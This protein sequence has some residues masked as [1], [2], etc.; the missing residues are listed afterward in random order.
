MKVLH[1]TETM[2]SGVLK[3][4]REVVGAGNSEE[5]KHFIIYSPNREYT[6]VD[7]DKL[8]PSTVTLIE[9]NI[10]I[11]YG[12]IQSMKALYVQ[13]SNIKPDVIH[14]HSSIAGF[15]GRLVSLW[16]PKVKVFY[17]PHGYSFLMT[18]KMKLVKMTYWLAEFILSQIN[19]QIIACSK[20]EYKYA[21]KISPLHK[22]YLLENCIKPFQNENDRKFSFRYKKQMIGVG[23]ME[24]QK[25]PK[26]FIEIIAELKKIDATI[27]AIWVGDG[28]LRQECEQLNSELKTNVFFTGWLSNDKTV[29]YLRDS[30]VFLQTSQWEGL[31]YSVLEAYAAGLPVVASNIESHRDLNENNYVCFIA[32]NKMQFVEHIVKLLNDEQFYYSSS[33]KNRKNIEGKYQKF[34][35]DIYSIYKEKFNE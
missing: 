29:E 23:R 22:H 21:Q 32:E 25:D 9:V 11:K 10:K 33:E 8:F 20:S 26:L 2:A 6:P 1:V 13:I 3:Y 16:F 12:F 30:T 28:S 4:L 35:R 5:V 14:L 18:N 15:I 27:K 24:H 31:P 7:L 34:S 19:G 17:T